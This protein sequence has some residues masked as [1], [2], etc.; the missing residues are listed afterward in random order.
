MERKLGV[1]EAREQLGNIVDQVQY[2]GDTYI[3]SRRGK[4]AAADS[5]AEADSA[6][7]EE[8][9]PDSDGFVPV[10]FVVEDGVAKAR[11][12]KTGIQSETHIEILEG[13]AEGDKIITG[14]Y[15]AISQTLQNN[16]PVDA[17][18]DEQ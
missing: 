11:Q 15:R 18:N 12:V 4:P 13:I 9:I 7:V 1:T 5:T 2:Q 3:L 16:A 17:G 14:S 10:I 6:A 8:Y